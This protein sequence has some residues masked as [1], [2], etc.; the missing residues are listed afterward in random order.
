MYISV[1]RDQ[2]KEGA[3]MVDQEIFIWLDPILSIKT[4]FAAEFYINFICCWKEIESEIQ[5]RIHQLI[6]IIHPIKHHLEAI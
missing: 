5:Y 3:I 6:K 1:Q 2:I 4:F